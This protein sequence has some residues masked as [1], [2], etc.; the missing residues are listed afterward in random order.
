MVKRITLSEAFTKSSYGLSMSAIT[1]GMAVPSFALIVPEWLGYANRF[2][3]LGL[4]GHGYDGMVNH[5]KCLDVSYR[6]NSA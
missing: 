6:H 1:H 2:Y 3:K 5:L 4:Q